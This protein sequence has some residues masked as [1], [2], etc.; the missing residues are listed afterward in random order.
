MALSLYIGCSQVAQSAPAESILLDNGMQIYLKSVE[1]NSPTI[2]LRLILRFGASD[3]AEGERGWAHLV[4]H[5]AFNGTRRFSAKRMNTMF[6]QADLRPGRDINAATGMSHTV[7]KL[8]VPAADPKLL[9]E[10]LGL[11]ADWL[12]SM[13]FSSESLAREKRIVAAEAL[14]FQDDLLIQQRWQ[15]TLFDAV[16]AKNTALGDLAQ[17]N[18]ASVDSLRRFWQR[19]YSASNAVLLVSGDFDSAA[20]AAKAR[21]ILGEL[22]KRDSIAHLSTNRYV[23]SRDVVLSQNRKLSDSQVAVAKLAVGHQ[24]IQQTTLAML[25]LQRHFEN[26]QVLANCGNISRRVETLPNAQEL[27]YLLRSSDTEQELSCLGEMSRGI[28]HLRQTG[29]DEDSSVQLFHYVQ[30]KRQQIE[31]LELALENRQLAEQLENRLIK[32]A[33]VQTEAERLQ[34]L[35]NWMAKQNPAAIKQLIVEALEPTRLSLIVQTAGASSLESQQ[36]RGLWAL[37]ATAPVIDTELRYK[38]PLAE[39][40]A[41]LPLRVTEVS[42]RQWTLQ[43]ANG[44]QVHLLLTDNVRDHFDVLLVREGGLLSLPSPLVSAAAQL[45]TVL[46]KIGLANHPAAVVQSAIR[47]HHLGFSWF[48]ENFRQGMR[49]SAR[50]KDAPALFSLLHQAQLPLAKKSFESASS[51]VISRERKELDDGGRQLR[52]VIWRTLYDLGDVSLP[53]APNLLDASSFQAARKRLF[54][55]SNDLQIH[56]AGDFDPRQIRQL[57]DKYIGS[58]PVTEDLSPAIGLYASAKRQRIVHRGN[59]RERADLFFYYVQSAANNLEQYDAE[60]LMLREVLA[61]RLWQVLREQEGLGY[62]VNLKLQRRPYRRGGSSLKVSMVSDPSVAGQI[63]QHVDDVF[64]SFLIGDVNNEELAP[65]RRRLLTD[66]Q[67]LLGDNASLLDEWSNQ[68][69]RGRSLRQVQ[70]T[71]AEIEAIDAEHLQQYA[72]QFF[73]D[74]G[75]LEVNVVPGLQRGV[76]GELPAVYPVANQ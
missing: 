30:S 44:A 39:A 29:L 76:S 51:A 17:V 40:N 71:I 68:R 11:I 1:N 13:E 14:E 62:G 75:F 43:Y 60:L 63:R 52:R 46:T 41:Q 61:Q 7:Y 5:M 12:S 47:E 15:Q 35:V 70:D 50:S 9:E 65:L 10:H 45:P 57:A 73:R 66:Y 26:H 34:D 27:H 42:D 2:D 72:R 31:S 4:E 58:L 24:Q 59:Q 28:L 22:P 55:G 25:A 67:K 6:Q 21:S 64:L 33:S 56:I 48:V 69:E 38:Y 23:S 53:A 37:D 54:T 16:P 74:T 3:E 8:T 20:V 32:Q 49:V 19:G 36:V 18:R